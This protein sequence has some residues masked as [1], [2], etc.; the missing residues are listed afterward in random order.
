MTKFRVPLVAI[1]LAVCAVALVFGADPTT[2]P[3]KPV[4]FDPDRYLAHVKYLASDELAG[5]LPGTEG[6]ELAAEYVARQFADAGL[7]PAGQDGTFFQSFEV[8]RGKKIVDDEATL[9]VDGI[10]HP[11]RVRH[12][13]IPLPFSDSGEVAGPLAFVGYGIRAKAYDYDDYAGFE[14]TDKIVLM[15]RYE[16]PAADPEAEFGGKETSR[17]ALFSGKAR[18]AH[19]EGAKAVLIVNPPSRKDAGDTLYEFRE[20]FSERTFDL[21]MVHVKRELADALVRKAGLGTLAELEE[22]LNRDRKPLSTDLGLNVTLK[23]GLHTNC[24]PTRNVLGLLRGTAGTDETIVVGAHYDHLGR[25]APTW[26]NA[27]TTPQIHNGAD[28]NASGTAAVIELARALGRAGG[29]RRNVLFA[30]FSAEEMG[31]LG[32]E[33]FLE[34]PT[35]PRERIRAMVNFDMVGRLGDGALTVF[36]THSATEFSELVRHAAEAVGLPYR[37]PAGIA[38]NS[39]HFPFYQHDIPVLFAF[40]GV[41]KQYHQPDDDWD[42]IDAAGA[43]RILATFCPLVREL[44]N[45]EAGPTFKTDTAEPKDED[46]EMKPAAEHER[47]A[48]KVEEP[49]GAGHADHPT[50]GEVEKPTRP[51]VRL[52]IMPDFTGSDQPGVVATAVLDGGAAKTAGMQDGDRII[53]INDHPIK[54]IYAY[55]DILRECKPGDALKVIV[56]RGDRELTLDIKLQEPPKPPGEQ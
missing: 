30:A 13:W 31:L 14:A 46:L 34:H 20:D 5:R 52:G 4:T 21:P 51:V 44:A 40:T 42:R 48:A 22:K 12:D 50:S 37:A 55:M 54:D 38:G 23:T 9:K 24:F 18:T 8:C 3:A 19:R 39:D 49:P 2:R 47:D 16:P 6:I 43:T 10:D 26:G 7:N 45:L 29:L 56:V 32:S 41:H 25:V 33:H 1:W 17:H 28:D 27:D 15:F 36:G 11:W 53:R 35:V